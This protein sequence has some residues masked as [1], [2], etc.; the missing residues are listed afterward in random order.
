[1]FHPLPTVSVVVSLV[2]GM[3]LGVIVSATDR[4]LGLIARARFQATSLNEARGVTKARTWGVQLA[5]GAA[6]IALSGVAVYA[7]HRLPAWAVIWF[8]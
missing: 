8:G 1:M 5:L 6:P 2:F 3:V 7:V 4:I